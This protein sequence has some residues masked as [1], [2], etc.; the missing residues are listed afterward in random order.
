MS[1]PTKFIAILLCLATAAFPADWQDQGVIH[2]DQSPHAKLHSVP[3]RAVTMGDGFWTPRRKVV[4]DKSIPGSLTLIEQAGVVDNFRRLTGKKNVPYRGPV[5]A[6]SDIYKWID[7]AGYELQSQDNPQLRKTVDGL[8]D[9]I[10]A[11]QEPNGYLGTKFTGPDAKDRLKTWTGHETY[12]LGHMLQGAASYYR[13][14]GDRKLLDAGARYVNYLYEEYAA[15]NKPIVCGHPELEMGAIELYRITRDKRH[16]DLAAYLLTSDWRESLKLNPETVWYSYTGVPF[17]ERTRVEGHAVRS[18]YA[19]SGA[20]DYY[21]ETGDLK[22]R[23]T[24]EKIWKTLVNNSM[25]VTGG[26]GARARQEAIGEAFELPNEAY[27]ESC[28]AIGSLMWN[29]RMFAATGEARFSDVMERALYNG[30]NS[31]LSL[32][33]TLYCYVNP[34][35]NWGQKTRNPWYTTACCPPNI[36]RTLGAIPG[37]LYSTSR[38]GV[39]INFF[40][41]SKLDWHLEDGTPLQLSQQTGYPWKGDVQVE[42]TPAKAAEFTVY[43]RI[44][45][46][47]PTATVAVNGKPVTGVQAGQYLA[48]HRQWRTG[49]KIA[50]SFDM[51]PQL[52]TA[53]PRVADDLG[54]V[55]VQRGPL[56]YCLEQ[57]DHLEPIA[58]LRLV[59][60]DFTSE[61]R[62]D[63][64]GGVMVLRQQGQAIVGD[65][66]L[67]APLGSSRVRTEKANL[68]LIPYY[69]WENRGPSAM[70]VWI[71]YHGSL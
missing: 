34:L 41:S 23:E 46:W 48:I 7:A 13:A 53:D 27:G 3:V 67:Y 8:I 11:V 50:A 38:D 16:L 24:L 58:S 68:T 43:L 65:Q 54:K 60:K 64:L 10:V 49:D 47:A 63:F 42:V 12:N 19:S 66:P 52:I 70:K 51:K 5:Y 15:K 21:L 6:D 44:P 17:T 39:Y 37:Y 2:V 33:G 26:V 14:T 57:P 20:T 40:H 22:F 69:A 31:G 71:P 45:G 30:I 62:G 55:A 9:E 29:W 36:E 61:F 18:M 4:F 1:R 59:S 28:A 25:Y 32:D 56:V 35:E